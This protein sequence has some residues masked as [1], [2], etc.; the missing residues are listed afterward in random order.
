MKKSIIIALAIFGMSVIAGAQ[1]RITDQSLVH[2][3]K[4][5]IVTFKIETDDNSI[6]SKRK[7]VI[8]PYIYNGKDTVW[9][10]TVEVYG[11][12]RYKREKQENHLKGNSGWDLEEGQMIKGDVYSYRD[13]AP[14]KRWM[15]PVN[16]GIRRE[17]VGCACEE[18]LA[19]EEVASATLFQEPPVE[20][21][22]IPKSF[23]LAD[24]TREWD[25]GQDELEI[26]FKVS[27]I[28]IDSSV[29]NNEITFGKILAAVDKIYS[30]PKFKVDKIEIAGY[31][32]PEGSR[33]FNNWLGENRAKALIDYIIESRPQYNL[34]ADNFRL[35]NG[36]E[37]WPGLRRLLLESKI[38]EK[39]QVIEIIDTDLPDDEKKQK[40]KA[41]D[42]GKIWKK[43]LDQV[44]PHL[45]CARYLAVYYDSTQDEAVDVIN[46]A[47]QMVREGRYAEAFEHLKPYDDDFRAYN[48]IGVSLMMQGEFEKA[49]PWFEKA[50]D[51]DF[52]AAQ[53]NIDVIDAELKYEELKRK[54]REEYLKR[55]E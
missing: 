18:D 44:Y 46:E 30:S 48:T 41:I 5:A 26:I 36:E 50:L 37:N 51:T 33:S 52:K 45:R 19:D 9:L 17:I 20:P 40:I 8:M 49:L 13:T 35:R 27:K 55:F 12:N 23:T 16:L 31:A 4:D 54:E 32:S 24:A 43:M 15:A 14:L 1:S 25:F 34:T 22:R 2:D 47:N 7:E 42:N 29:F 53:E 11:K 10:E 38:E 39:N 28:E 21:R 6:P 3:G